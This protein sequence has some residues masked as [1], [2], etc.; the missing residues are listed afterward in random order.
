M[1]IRNICIVQR[2]YHAVPC[3]IYD[4]SNS[5]LIDL[6]FWVFMR[7]KKPGSSSAIMVGFCYYL[8]FH[9]LSCMDEPTTAILGFGKIFKEH[10]VFL[11]FCSLF[12]VKSLHLPLQ[13]IPLLN[14][15]KKYSVV[16]VYTTLYHTLKPT[17]SACEK[18]KHALHELLISPICTI[19]YHVMLKKERKE[20]CCLF[21]RIRFV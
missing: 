1:S 4:C 7:H 11:E 8:I 9:C 14:L 18:T 21:I 17:L 6:T 5:R 10:L 20:K 2:H 16:V 13:I 3:S 15:T 19:I 12:R